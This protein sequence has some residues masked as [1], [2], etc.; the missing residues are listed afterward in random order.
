V[1]PE[2]VHRTL[3]FF[4][5]VAAA[6]CV[7]EL[8][9][10]RCAQLTVT[11]SA[12]ALLFVPWLAAATA[13]LGIWHSTLRQRPRTPFVRASEVLLW[14]VSAAFALAFFALYGWLLFGRS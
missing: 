4:A 14:L 3:Q 12:V 5:A 6:A 2:R 10:L 8:F 11:P 13:N 1:T 7:A 9:W